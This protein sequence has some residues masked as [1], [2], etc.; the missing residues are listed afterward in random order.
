MN[1]LIAVIK[2]KF[3]FSIK[4]IESFTLGV[5]YYNRFKK[6]SIY[7][8][9]VG[10]PRS[11]HSLIGALLSAH[12]NVMIAHELDALGYIT[13]GFNKK[14][15]F[16]LIYDKDREFTK[17]GCMESG[18]SYYVPNQWQGKFEK[19]YVIGDKKGGVSSKMLFQDPYLL[20]KLKSK[21]NMPIKIIHVTRNPFDVISGINLWYPTPLIDS[22]SYF[23]S[24]CDANKKIINSK[25]YDIVSIK[26]EDFAIS[27]DK[28]IKLLCD[29]INVECFD[30]YIVDCKKL[31]R[32]TRN[33]NRNKIEWPNQLKQIVLNKIE[34][35]DFLKGYSFDN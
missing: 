15:L 18:Y 6:A 8:M 34:E 5:L 32:D 10:Y 30:N 33:K 23:F 31:V 2:N 13:K 21:L 19:L 22:I 20:E 14:Q 11:G 29:F 35:Y 17:S 16:Y 4:Y 24:L 25:K 7:C 9:F 28:Y 27:P 12:K 3:Y 1:R 26:Y